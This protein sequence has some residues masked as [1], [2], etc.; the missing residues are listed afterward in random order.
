[1]DEL[2]IG[3]TEI[4]DLQ[5][6]E[7]PPSSKVLSESFLTKRRDVD[8]F[9]SS[10]RKI[11]SQRVDQ[12]KVGLYFNKTA[13]IKTTNGAVNQYGRSAMPSFIDGTSGGC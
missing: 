1:M 7:E 9:S 5:D 12:V 8:S 3:H 11:A 4:Q 6:E 2:E 10:R 13:P